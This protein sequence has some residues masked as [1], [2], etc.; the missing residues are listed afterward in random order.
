MLFGSHSCGHTVRDCC[1]L[2]REEVVD[3][4]DE[5]VFVSRLLAFPSF[6]CWLLSFSSFSRCLHLSTRIMYIHALCQ[7]FVWSHRAWPLYSQESILRREEVVDL[8]DETVFASRLLVFLFFCVHRLKR[9]R[10]KRKENTKPFRCS[11]AESLLSR[12]L[13]SSAQ[14]PRSMHRWKIR[15]FRY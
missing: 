4:A 13:H 5:I 1:I 7:A 14:Q 2:R 8:A 9:I 12:Q 6:V 3:W 15:F 11:L 10:K